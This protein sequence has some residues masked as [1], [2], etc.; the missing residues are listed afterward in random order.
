MK[1]SQMIGST[2]AFDQLRGALNNLGLSLQ[3]TNR[4]TEA[5]PR[6]RRMVEIFM[7]F[8]RD[9]GHKP[10]AEALNKLPAVMAAV[11]MSV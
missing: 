8:I 3:A 4:L 6:I 2:V 11:G 1:R 5:E 10:S 7:S 9:T